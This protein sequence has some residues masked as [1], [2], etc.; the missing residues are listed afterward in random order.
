LPLNSFTPTNYATVAAFGSKST[1]YPLPGG[2]GTTIRIVNLGEAPAVVLLGTGT[3]FVV[4]PQTG[5]AV[6]PRDSVAV[7]VGSNDHI[8]VIAIGGLNAQAALNISQGA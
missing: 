2:G 7:I 8:A 4:T 6:V 1:I 3:G 5:M